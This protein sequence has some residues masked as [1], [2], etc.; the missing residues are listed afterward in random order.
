MPLQPQ[1]GGI[2]GLFERL[3]RPQFPPM[4]GFGG[5]GGGRFGPPPFYPGMRGGFFGGLF[6][7]GSDKK[8]EDEPEWSKQTPLY[9]RL[10]TAPS[11]TKTVA[12]SYDK[13]ILCKIEYDD[14]QSLP[15]GT[16]Y[17]QH[18]QCYDIIYWCFTLYVSLEN[19]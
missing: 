17:F 14:D 13:D 16:F 4:G 2:A 7:G 8:S 1:G 6:G 9:P 3:R 12:F 10:S 18:C 15:E 5:F 19:E 11:K